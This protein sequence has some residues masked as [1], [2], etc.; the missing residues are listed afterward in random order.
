MFC[1]FGS[2]DRR[3]NKRIQ[4]RIS[5]VDSKSATLATMPVHSDQVKTAFVKPSQVRVCVND[6]KLSGS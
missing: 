2:L 1:R 5:P 6:S 3:K 4:R